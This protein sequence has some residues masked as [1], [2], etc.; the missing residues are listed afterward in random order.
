MLP[1]IPRAVISPS[2]IPRNSLR[3]FETLCDF[4][5]FRLEPEDAAILAY[6][7][8]LPAIVGVRLIFSKVNPSSPRLLTEV[9]SFPP[10]MERQ[11]WLLSPN[12]TYAS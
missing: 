10:S 6:D 12:R 7:E 1:E 5:A 4:G 11:T 2:P 8:E 3:D 9:H